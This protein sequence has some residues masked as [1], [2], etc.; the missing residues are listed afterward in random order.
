MMMRLA[1]T[2]IFLTLLALSIMGHTCEER[3]ENRR[4]DELKRTEMRYEYNRN[5]TAWCAENS[6]D[7]Q[8]CE[9]DRW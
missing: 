1:A 4:A 3:R 7:R 9:D 2:L 8:A 5:M 6:Y